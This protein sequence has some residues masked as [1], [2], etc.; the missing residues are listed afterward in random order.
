MNIRNIDMNLLVVFDTLFDERSATRAADRLALTLPAVSGMLKWLRHLFSDELFV[1]TSHGIL[2]TPR[3]EALAVPIKDLL[4]TAP[5]LITPKS[6]DPT[7][8]ETT[9][10]LCGNDY[11]QSAVIGPAIKE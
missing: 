5:A 10:A 9:L 2:P 1:R 8:A 11:M 6:F 7:T 4:G 3:A